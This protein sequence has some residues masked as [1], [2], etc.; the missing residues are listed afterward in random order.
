MKPNI[1]CKHPAW[2]IILVV[3][4]VFSILYVGYTQYKYFRSFVYQKGVTDA[5]VKVIQ[6]AQK[7]KAFPV[8]LGDQVVQLVNVACVTQPKE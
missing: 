5:V 8:K 6:S 4:V 2:K 3:W 1:K 7:C